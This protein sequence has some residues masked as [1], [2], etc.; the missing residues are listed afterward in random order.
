MIT[1]L[2]D[3]GEIYSN[4]EPSYSNSEPSSPFRTVFKSEPLKKKFAQFLTTI[5][6]QLDEEK[7][8]QK[9]EAIVIDPSKSDKEIY[10]NLTKNI[11]Q[12]RKL[13]PAFVYQIQALSKLQKG[14]GQQAAIL[15]ED[16]QSG[17][18]HNYLEIYFR[19]YA[20]TIKKTAKLPLDGLVFSA[21]D[22]N[23]KGGIKE[24]IEADALF[25]SYPYTDYVPLNDPDCNDPEL[26][27]EKTHQPIGGEVSGSSIDL[28][29]VLG[30]LHHVPEK[31]LGSF[32]D[33]LRQKLR[34]GGVLLLRDHDVV[35]PKLHAIASVVHSF[36]NAANGTP[37]EVEKNE[38]RAF[39]SA[40]EWVKFMEKHQFIRVSPKQ[41]ILKDD[42]TRNAMMAFVRKPQNL[43]ELKIAAKYRKDSV[44]PVDGTKATWLEWANVRYSKQFASFIQGHHVHAFD[45]IG[46]LKQHWTHF[47]H[48]FCAARKDLSRK[49]VIMS[50]NFGM[51]LFI[52]ASAAAECLF[53]YIQTLPSR[54]I[55]QFSHSDN[56]QNKTRHFTALE[57]Y[58]QQVAKD[59]A[60]FIEKT[61]FYLFPYLSRIQK[62]WGAIWN[63][64]ESKWTKLA[65]LPD[66]TL[67]TLGWGLKA[68]V[69]APIQSSYVKEDGQYVEPDTVSILIHDPNNHFTTGVKKI[70][71]NDFSI[72]VIY[73][74][75]DQ[76]KLVTVPR[77][78]PFTLLCKELAMSQD[79]KLIEV[80]SQPTIT[81][82][83]V[84]DDQDH[85][86]P[87]ARRIYK[88]NKLQDPERKCYY[89]TYEVDVSSLQQFIDQVGSD[90]IEYVHEQRL[91]TD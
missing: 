13:L 26:Q 16:F 1:T 70:A 14:M 4:S 61:P 49:E 52:L 74:T 21:A 19:R 54:I 22:Q 35:N 58:K 44:R 38:I 27:A 66:A 3:A 17:Q 55:A 43:E 10:E 89:A 25:S 41:L 12:M 82:D 33:S 15:M 39:K 84:E 34:P 56:A 32:V 6:Y 53:G 86:I 88:L 29:A 45:Y 85:D 81:V 67:T 47:T 50:E 5:F 7:V 36:V 73:Q 18:F 28:I 37:W 79:V 80:G 90:K 72:K 59:Y 77:Y 71:G 51:N 75:P 48:Y 65:S 64:E 2:P 63:A 24:K 20:N 68:L 62:M 11:D 69:S 87:N 9:M 40:Q 91:P 23:Y 31:R 46:H 57:K 78:R 60:Q 42:P 83:V 76:Y 8:L 30:G